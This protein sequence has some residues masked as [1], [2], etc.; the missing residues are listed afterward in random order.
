M[1]SDVPS[2][3]DFSEAGLGFINLAWDAAMSVDYDLSQVRKCL[4]DDGLGAGIPMVSYQRAL[5][6][7]IALVQQGTE[8]LLKAKIVEVSP[9]LLISGSFRDWPSGCDKVDVPFSV[10]RTL[11]A[12]DLVRV[13]DAV[14]DSRLPADFKDTFDRLRRQRNTIFHTVDKT[15]RVTLA[16]V[17]KMFLES[18]NALVEQHSWFRLRAGF[19]EASPTA[20]A[21]SSHS[22]VSLNI[23]VGK[24]VELLEPA[25]LLRLTGFNKKARRYFC[26]R[27][28]R[29]CDHFDIVSEELRLG[30][31]RPNSSDS[32]HVFCFACQKEY[33]VVRVRCSAPGCKGNVIWDED[34]YAGICATCG[35]DAGGSDE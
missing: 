9:Y 14:A 11:D 1:I 4:D 19:L 35:Q 33:A 13:H 6:T 21:D 24:A 17:V 16:D 3:G 7:S 8:L 15:L 31:L 32:T 2:A 28:I 18:V 30:Q 12:Q 27:C 22:V 34:Y 5:V 20:A 23:E 26:A 10:F 29:E 25:D